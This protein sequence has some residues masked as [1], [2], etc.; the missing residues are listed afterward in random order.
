MTQTLTLAHQ[1]KLISDKFRS[2][3]IT[4]NDNGKFEAWISGLCVSSSKKVPFAV[5]ADS[6]DGAIAAMFNALTEPDQTIKYAAPYSVG[7]HAYVW[8]KDAQ[9]FS[10]K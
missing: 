10:L 5:S 9:H 7:V 6:A 1:H 4:C 8:D 3:N 2:I